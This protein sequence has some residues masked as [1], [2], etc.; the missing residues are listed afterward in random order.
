MGIMPKQR[1]PPINYTSFTISNSLCRAYVLV[2][3]NYDVIHRLFRIFSSKIA[4]AP[5]SSVKPPILEQHLA[6]KVTK[7]S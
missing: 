6:A 3:E 7:M 1:V 4:T 2:L 5:L